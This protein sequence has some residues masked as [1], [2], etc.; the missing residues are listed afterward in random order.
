MR[1]KAVICLLVAVA[2]LAAPKL[3]IAFMGIEPSGVSASVASG[4]SV[5]FR[6]ALIN[7]RRFEVVERERLAALMEEQGLAL[8][9]CTTTEC[10]VKVGQLADA[11]KVI[12]GEVAQVGTSYIVSVRLV[13]VYS[14]R[15]EQSL[16]EVSRS[17]EGLLTAANTLAVQLSTTISVEGT[18]VSVTGNTIKTD[19]GS[20]EGISVNDTVYLVRLGEEYYHPETGLF[21]GRDIRELGQATITRILAD[22]LSEAVLKG[23]FS[24]VVG[25][26]V[27]LTAPVSISPVIE[28]P[29]V[30]SPVVSPSGAGRIAFA[31]DRDGDSEI[32]VMD[33]DGGNQIQLTNNTSSDYEPAWSPDGRRIAFAS[34]PDVAEPWDFEI[35]VMDADG[36]NQTQLTNNTSLDS[37]PAWSP[38][39]RRIAFWSDRGGDGYERFVMDADGSNQT[40]LTNNTSQD[41]YPGWS[42]DGRHFAFESARDGD[43]EIFVMDADGS[44]QTQLTYN[45]SIDKSPV[46][47]PDGRR[48]AFPSNRDGDFEIYVMD[49]DGSNQTQLTDNT[50]DDDSPAWCP[51]E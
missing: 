12:V 7:T 11:Q 38:D 31:S 20:Q 50:S 33:T 22:E 35:F 44:N 29:V 37:S 49:A 19:L 4:V 43:Q 48:I 3:K 9:G 42:P 18:V 17:L 47:S 26:K 1:K 25:D 23:T 34:T 10:F 40:Q 39:D 2:A 27:R 41:G 36:R 30:I 15:V 51:V 6:D 14:G 16:S 45:D 8:S 46:W 21:L 24:V 13:D 28:T 32:F 5:S